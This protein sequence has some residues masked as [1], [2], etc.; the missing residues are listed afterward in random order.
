[1][2]SF[3]VR[4]DIVNCFS[5][6][7]QCMSPPYRGY[8]TKQASSF[9][10]NYENKSLFIFFYF[11]F[12]RPPFSPNGSFRLKFSQFLVLLSYFLPFPTAYHASISSHLP[13][14][15]PLRIHPCLLQVQQLP[16]KS[17][18]IRKK[19]IF[20]CYTYLFITYQTQ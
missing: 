3:T 6:G 18:T 4:A 15:L 20:F 16:L 12:F 7:W 10:L 1:M 5:L 11:I 8:T 13:P 14:H 19:T 17:C 2:Q 9:A